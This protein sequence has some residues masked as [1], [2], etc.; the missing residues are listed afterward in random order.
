MKMI[1]NKGLKNEKRKKQIILISAPVKPS[2]SCNSTL[3]AFSKL[4]FL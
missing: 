2:L 1:F 4:T 3:G